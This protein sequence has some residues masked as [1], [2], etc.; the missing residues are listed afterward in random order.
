MLKFVLLTFSLTLFFHSLI[1]GV[2]RAIGWPEGS[3]SGLR[4]PNGTVFC[5]RAARD[6]GPCT[7]GIGLSGAAVSPHLASHERLEK[8]VMKLGN[9]DSVQYVRPKDFDL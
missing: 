2:F 4:S 5:E 9:C 7:G 3:H 6:A 8:L 1:L